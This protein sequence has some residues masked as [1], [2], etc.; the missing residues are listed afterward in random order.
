MNT[1]HLAYNEAE[2]NVDFFFNIPPNIM[3][4][5]LYMN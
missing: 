5:P 3:K 1:Q 4:I 2:D